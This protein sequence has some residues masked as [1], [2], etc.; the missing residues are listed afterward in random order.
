MSSE[1]ASNSPGLSPVKGQKPNLRTKTGSWDYVTLEP[2]FG[3]YQDLSKL[4]IHQAVATQA[5]QQI[6]SGSSILHL[7]LKVLIIRTYKIKVKVTPVQAIRLC[8][9]RTAHRGRRGIAL[10]FHGH[11]TRSGWGVSV[12]P[13][14]LFTSG[15]EPVPIVQEAGWF[16][17][18][19]W[20]GAENLAPTGIRS[21]DR[22]AHS[23]SLYRLS[24]PA[25][26]LWMYNINFVPSETAP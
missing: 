15:K 13:R 16:T 3:F 19:V 6:L 10:P 9:G 14:P 20:T 1:K 22:P 5:Q 11:G 8:T 17:G 23:Q 12:T 7:Q 18:P 21:P 26:I 2:V 25:H 4:R 24:Y